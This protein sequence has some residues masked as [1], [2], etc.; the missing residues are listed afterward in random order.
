MLT[1]KSDQGLPR[2]SEEEGP[3]AQGCPAEA[4][5]QPGGGADLHGADVPGDAHAEDPDRPV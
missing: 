2:P 4:R 5:L 3:G 1:L